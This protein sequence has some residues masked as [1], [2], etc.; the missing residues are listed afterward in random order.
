MK[1]KVC[2]LYSFDSFSAQAGGG[3]VDVGGCELHTLQVLPPSF[4]PVIVKVGIPVS[5][6]FQVIPGDTQT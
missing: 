5:C 4:V 3:R 6:L 2:L 1:R